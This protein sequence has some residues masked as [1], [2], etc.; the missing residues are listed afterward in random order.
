[1]TLEAVREY[2]ASLGIAKDDNC[3]MGRM[4]GKKKESIGVYKLKRSGAPKIPIGG[5][6]N[7]RYDVYPVSLLVHWDASPGRTEAAAVALFE[8]LRDM[9]NVTIEDTLLCFCE[10]LVPEPV[11]VGSDETGICEM[12]IEVLFYYEIMKGKGE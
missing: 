10:L 5:M 2:V 1:M 8:A 4:D 11:D 7:A 3:Y 12:V 9:G 6:E